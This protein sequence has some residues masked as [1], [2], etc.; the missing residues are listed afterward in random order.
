MAKCA[1]CGG[2]VTGRAPCAYCGSVQELDRSKLGSYSV[3]DDP[4]NRMCP[5][6]DIP[7]RTINVGQGKK[8][9]IEQCSSCYGLFFDP[10]ELE[11]LMNESTSEV[12]SIKLQKID[13][14]SSENFMEDKIVY[15]KCPICRTLMNRKNFGGRSGIIIDICKDHGIWLDRGELSAL[16]EWKQAG[17]QI[18]KE[19][20]EA[21]R[22]KKSGE[23]A[24]QKHHE[25]VSEMHRGNR[26]YTSHSESWLETSLSVLIK[27]ITRGL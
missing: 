3:S 18:L 9:Y 6:C 21:K 24:A 13:K 25:Y 5:C 8:F 27:L 22:V 26:R 12:Y 17:G 19:K 16:L 23:R 4:S 2:E 10:D 1:N 14:L 15:R 7:L 11:A 20:A